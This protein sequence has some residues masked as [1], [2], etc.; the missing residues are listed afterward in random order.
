MGQSEP[1][2]SSQSGASFH[3]TERYRY[4]VAWSLCAVYLF[5]QIDRQIFAILQHPI[6]LEFNFSD[7]QLGLIGGTAFG[8]CYATFA[9]PIARIADRGNRV[10]IISGALAVWSL[11]TAVTGLAR[12]FWQ[13]M[14]SRLI[15]GIGEAGC[16]PPAY[17]I[18]SD[19][20]EPKR[21]ATA[22][23]IY[24]L[25]VSGGSII[26]LLVGSKVAELYGWRTAFY[27]M[28]LP[29]VLLAVIVRLTLREPPRGFSEPSAAREERPPFGHVLALAWT[30]RSFRYL[31]AGAALY[32][33]AANGIGAFYSV[34]LI[35]SHGMGL[36]ETGRWLALASVGG[37]AGTYLGGKLADVLAQRRGDARWL[38]WMPAAI[39]LIN[40]PISVL[41]YT[42]ADRTAVIALLMI[43]VSMSASYIAPTVA[44]TQRLVGARE[45]ALAAAILFF[46]MSL[47]GIGAGP[48]VVGFLSDTFKDHL[49][50]GGTVAAAASADGL[51]Y[52]FLCILGAPML[53]IFFYM[54][55]AASIR[56]ELVA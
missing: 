45:R 30:K 13:M 33:I 36:S 20:F 23:G 44:A 56:Q 52:A 50:L 12:N 2:R 24:S 46:V 5:N 42:A 17:S 55:A 54:R 39:L 14:L 8:L 26:G 15:V 53:A 29:G 1:Q 19:Y 10:N 49:L 51:R 31:I 32:S 48:T 28:G 40:L 9:I 22:I 27:V 6:K 16:S 38:M 18:I 11:F 4:Y 25:G 43:N 37:M 35:R 34:F 21:R 41:L 7:L 3:V 47:I